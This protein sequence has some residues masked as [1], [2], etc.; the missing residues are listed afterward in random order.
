MHVRSTFTADGISGCLGAQAGSSSCQTALVD[1]DRVVNATRSGG[2]G[3]LL[4]YL[5]LVPAL[6]GMFLGAPL[7]TREF[8][9]G[10][11]RL[12]W[13]QSVTRRRWLAY[14]VAVAGSIAV[15]A[16]LVLSLALMFQRAPIDRIA[17]RFSPESFNVEGLAPLGSVW[18]ALVVGLCAGAL[19]RKTVPAM[20]CSLVAF[21]AV[22]AAVQDWI[23]PHYLPA[24][25][26]DVRG[27]T[28][29]S[30]PNGTHGD[31]ILTSGSHVIT[32]QPAGRYWAFQVIEL[33][34]YLALSA[35]LLVVALRSV[36][37]RI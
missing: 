21:L 12:A 30:T 9:P 16:E 28:S 15:I 5:G 14:R 4:L 32:Y 1:F 22:R 8:E 34:V 18:F 19:I 10:T 13:T 23:R 25:S 24:R 3:A 37:R 2:G 11:H 36:G 35:P 20:A 29:A 17:G 6:L 33:L 27:L 7:L 26:I 31:W